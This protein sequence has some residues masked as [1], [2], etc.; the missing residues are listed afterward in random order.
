MSK[1]IT[2]NGKLQS[3]QK[4]FLIF[5]MYAMLG[6]IYEV[7]LEV[8]IYRW[9]FTNRGVLFGPYCPVYGV[10][11]LAFLFTVSKLIRKK[12]PDETWK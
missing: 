12:K 7:V 10:G 6:W 8:F 1:Q 2:D 9:G 3:V 4:Y 11:A 5:I